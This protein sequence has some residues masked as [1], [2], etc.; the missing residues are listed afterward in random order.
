MAFINIQGREIIL[1]VKNDDYMQAV[2][3]LS[4]DKKWIM[5]RE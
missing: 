2:E 4:E 3:V 5:V 1:V